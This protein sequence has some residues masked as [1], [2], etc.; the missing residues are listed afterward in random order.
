MALLESHSLNLFADYHQF[1]I[2][3]ESVDADWSSAWTDEAVSQMVAVVP[4]VV[5]VGTSSN[6]TVPVVL[7]IH[8]A[9]PVADST[10]WDR[11]NE[12]DLRVGS[13]RIVIA[14]CTDYLPDAR[15]FAA[16]AGNYRVRVSYKLSNGEKYR[17]Q[18]WRP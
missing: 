14:G 15:R 4:G 11:V 12:C 10:G 9:E 5:A 8:D 13:D 17:V 6:E 7:E 2:Q 3:D 16:P 1:Y 18:L